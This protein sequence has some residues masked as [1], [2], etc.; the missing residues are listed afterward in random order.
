MTAVNG[1][2]D[3]SGKVH[4]VVLQQYHIEESDAVV[5]AAANLHGLLLEHTHARRSL[6]G[7][8]HTGTS[9]L[10]PFHIAGGHRSNATHA[11]HDVQ[12]QA[13]S[14]QQRTY[15]T[16]DNHSDVA[17]LN[18]ASVTHQHLDL[19]LSIE[20]VEHFLGYFHASQNTVFLNQQMTLA[21]RILGDTA[22]GS[23]VAITNV[24]GKRQVNK[25]VN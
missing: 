6:A 19:H 20:T 13:L 12:H 7:I 2:H 25:S 18:L 9:P 5:T 4:V 21:H 3:T 22:Q 11:L 10:Q 23:M 17:F 1:I 8:E 16:G 15:L 24:L 14:L